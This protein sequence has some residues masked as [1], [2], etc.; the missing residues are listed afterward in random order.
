MAEEFIFGLLGYPLGHSLSPRIHLAALQALSL[1]GEYQLFEIQDEADLPGLFDQ[2][3]EGA[4][5]GLNVTI[6]YKRSVLKFLDE[7]TPAARAIGAVNT[8]SFHKQQLIGGNTDAGGFLADMRRLGWFPGPDQP[9][10][11]LILG[12]GGSA[13]A[14]AFSLS[15]HNWHIKIAARRVA[16]AE[17]LGKALLENDT[18]HQKRLSIEAIHLDRESLSKIE[19][20]PDL[21]VN[22]TPLG[23]YPQ[24]DS[25]P[26][27]AGVPLPAGT[28]VYDLVYH[29]AETEFARTAGAAGLR[30]ASGVGMLVEQ[31]ALS[32]E[33]WTGF[34]APRSEMHAAL[35]SYLV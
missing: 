25:S 2:L 26:W 11:A 12:A 15:Q 21:I 3:R 17:N 14:V 7:L 10:Q 4:L 27:P 24:D 35:D 19:P 9:R 13:R 18:A 20:S 33:F 29:P 23:M 8:I 28:A 16:Q 34:T 22:T 30:A 32:F 5:H 1:Q 31:A 6:P